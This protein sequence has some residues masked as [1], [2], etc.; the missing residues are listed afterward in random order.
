MGLSTS[1]NSVHACYYAS[2]LACTYTDIMVMNGMS[3][4]FHEYL[5]LL[6]PIIT[7]QVIKILNL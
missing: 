2:M 7:A 5:Y 4:E 1:E 6:D 3:P